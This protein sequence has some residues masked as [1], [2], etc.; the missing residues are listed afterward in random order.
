VQKSYAVTTTSNTIYTDTDATI[1]C[2]EATAGDTVMVFN[3]AGEPAVNLDTACPSFSIKDEF[4]FGAHIGT[5][6][7]CEST[8]DTGVT[9]ASLSA[10]EGSGGYV[11]TITFEYVNSAAPSSVPEPNSTVVANTTELITGSKTS[12]V[13]GL[14]TLIPLGAVLLISVA[15]VFFVLKR[16]RAI[17]RN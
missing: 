17:V 14:R 12:V 11:N 9:A 8:D 7:I 5:W 10:C 3:D 6:H 15:V 2:Q 1:T 4:D 13:G 16:F